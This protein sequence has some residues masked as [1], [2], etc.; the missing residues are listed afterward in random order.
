MMS[1]ASLLSQLVLYTDVYS[2]NAQVQIFNN[3]LV[4]GLLKNLTAEQF[5]RVPT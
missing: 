5:K 3:E 2:G 1:S 4:G